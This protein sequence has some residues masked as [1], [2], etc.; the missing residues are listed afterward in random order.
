MK[1]MVTRTLY[2][3]WTKLRGD[4][5]APDRRDIEPAEI[6]H[7]LGDTFILEAE[8]GDAFD[9]RLAG[10]RICA[11]YGRELKGRA[12]MSLFAAADHDALR[13]MVAA[14]VEDGAAAV[15]GIRGTSDRG[16][17]VTIE[18]MLMPLTH[19]D[20]MNTRI[21]G[22]IAAMEE[23]YWLEVQPIMQQAVTGLRVIWPDER[24]G[25]L[26]ATEGRTHRMHVPQLAI[27]TPDK[28]NAMRFSA[29]D[30]AV[31]PAG[32]PAGTNFGGD[33]GLFERLPDWIRRPPADDILP[34]PA[35]LGQLSVRRVNH[36]TVIDG[37]K[38]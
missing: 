8:E 23:P 19:Q 26:T 7:I 35:V 11:I 29:L 18:M 30:L 4:R 24:P 20:R 36:L 28:N 13:S 10:T 3:Y 27:A 31:S 22:S 38:H 32:R 14:V 9:F 25:F 5:I 16:N 21:L 34:E 15:I 12:L 2:S 33:A 17:S 1:H 37:G 6:R